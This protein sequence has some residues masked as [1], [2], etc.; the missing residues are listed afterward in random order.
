MLPGPELAL[1]TLRPV[2]GG[3]HAALMARANGT[4][5]IP[6]PEAPE[7][8][9]LLTADAATLEDALRTARALSRQTVGDGIE[10]VVAAR[11]DVAVEAVA[12]AADRLRVVDARSSKTLGGALNAAVRSARGSLALLMR[13]G[14]IPATDLVEQHLA[15]LTEAGPLAGASEPCGAGCP[16]ATEHRG[17]GCGAPDARGDL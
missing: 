13:D 10:I 1:R 4:C 5:P 9:A 2:R 8:S 3:L 14:V 16:A 6:A 15:D 7:V 12:G 17:R 11:D